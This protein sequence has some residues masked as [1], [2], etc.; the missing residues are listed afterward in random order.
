MEEDRP[1][2]ATS[3]NE[4]TAAENEL[5]DSK[6]SIQEVE[7]DPFVKIDLGQG[8]KELNEAMTRGESKEIRSCYTNLTKTFPTAVIHSRLCIFI[9]CLYF[10]IRRI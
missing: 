3:L 7:E 2:P 1:H 4:E 8:L 9:I 6:S 5:D 10:S